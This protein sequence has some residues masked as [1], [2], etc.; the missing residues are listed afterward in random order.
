MKNSPFKELPLFI[1]H[2]HTSTAVNK[3]GSWRFFY[4]K[5]DEKTAPC[6]AACPVGQ[7]I[8]RIEMLTSWGLLKDA[9]Q[10]ILNENPFPAVCGRVCFHPCESACNR[11]DLDAP[12]A[13]HSLER[14]LADTALSNEKIPDPNINPSRDQKVAIAGAGPAGLSAAYFLSRLGYRCEVFEAGCA[15]GGMLRLGIPGYRLPRAIL[16]H[17][18]KRIE[19]QGVMIHCKNPVT[20]DRLKKICEKYDALFIGCGYGRSIRLKIDGGHLADDGLDFLRRLHQGQEMSFAG[21][22]VVFGGGNTAIDVARSLA[23]LGAS[24]LIVYRRRIQD[25]PAFEPEVEMALQEGVEI[26]ELA[27]PIHIQQNLSDSYSSGYTLT[28]QHM[29]PGKT[30]ISGRTRVIPDG[31]KTE[32]MT[33]QN[34]F[35]AIGAEADALWHFPATDHTRSLSLSHCRLI[36]QKIPLVFGGDLTSPVKSVADAIASGK[37]AAMALNTYFAKGLEAVAATLAGCRVGPGPALSMETY[38]A[39]NRQDRNAHVV[40]YDEIVTDYFQTAPRV[41]PSSLDAN[42]RLQS[43]AEVES[44]LT[45]KVAKGEAARCFSCGNCNACDYCRLYCPE[46]AVKVDK[47]QRS[48]DMDYCKGCGVC[49]T[50]CPRNAM[51]LEEEIK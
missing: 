21:K 46:M 4:P 15:P 24:P 29:K 47:G 44:T 32:T 5:Y 23:R 11:G 16:D 9:W 7:D 25:M 51:A 19:N 50:E 2:S 6:S 33:A 13:I 34:I 49:A 27:A 12:I 42:R 39:G 37:Q 45:D 17:E 30:K 35:V 38:L 36:E 22:A 40:T 14:F 1:P 8:A 31:K 3:T 20:G 48:I 18:I 28:L 41:T 26:I 10:L 43:F